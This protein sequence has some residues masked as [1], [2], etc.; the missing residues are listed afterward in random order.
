MLF[1]SPKNEHKRNSTE[2]A[3]VAKFLAQIERS[4]DAKSKN[5]KQRENRLNIHYNELKSFFENNGFDV[6]AEAE[7][8]SQ[9]VKQ[10]KK[11]LIKSRYTCMRIFQYLQS[12]H[13]HHQEIPG[14]SSVKKAK[15][16][17][18]LESGKNKLLL[19]NSTSISNAWA[20]HKSA[21]HLITA[22]NMCRYAARKTS[23]EGSYMDALDD[24]DFFLG[25]ALHFQDVALS[26]STGS[27]KK[28]PIKPDEIW[29]LSNPFGVEKI[30]IPAKPLRD[31]QL[32]WLR[33]Y[34]TDFSIK[35][36]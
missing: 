3:F 17:V 13:E 18:K 10:D 14:G 24:I 28:P 19:K 25:L 21:A 11:T 32:A 22:Y 15:Y 20:A 9:L 1:P 6:V 33:G 7:S 35:K 8:V 27:R 5:I 12:M 30:A 29:R 34:A 31:D 16:L 36:Q 2:M 4:I 26:F 23:P